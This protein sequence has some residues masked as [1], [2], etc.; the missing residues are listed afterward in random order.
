LDRIVGWQYPLVFEIVPPEH[1][2]ADS[3]PKSATFSP[4]AGDKVTLM[5]LRSGTFFSLRQ[6][7]DDLVGDV[8]VS[9]CLTSIVIVQLLRREFL[10]DS[11]PAER[12]KDVTR[13]NKIG[14]TIVISRSPYWR[15]P[16]ESDESTD[17]VLLQILMTFPRQAQATIFHPLFLQRLR[18]GN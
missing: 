17:G 1:L 14:C 13:N 8:A 9:N 16:V 12:P 3:A 11:C 4:D 7:G 18:F 5:T 10:F 2:Q 15:Y 6:V